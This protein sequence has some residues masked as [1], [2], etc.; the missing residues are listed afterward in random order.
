MAE[1]K[2]DVLYEDSDFEI[3]SDNEAD[4][5]QSELPYQ[6]TTNEPTT[7]GSVVEPQ[8]HSTKN[9]LNM[10]ERKRLV[11]L[12]NITEVNAFFNDILNLAIFLKIARFLP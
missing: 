6:S 11:D 12:V 1:L 8:L 3:N 7:D 4:L 5:E 10:S 2:R 9:Q